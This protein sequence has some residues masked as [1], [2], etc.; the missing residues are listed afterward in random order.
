MLEVLGIRADEAFLAPV[1]SQ[2]P[3]LLVSGTLDANT[4]VHQAE[5]VARTLAKATQ[6]L[7]ENAGHD[8][9]LNDARIREHVVSFLA[10]DDPA[11]ERIAL[12]PYRFAPMEGASDA[13]P[14][15]MKR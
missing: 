14:S 11:D 8:D 5:A 15:I 10:G 3:C 4:P 12:A 13:H 6:L 7:V 1:V 9:L 2:V